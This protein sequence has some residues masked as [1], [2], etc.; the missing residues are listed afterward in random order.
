MRSVWSG[1][2]PLAG[3]LVILNLLDGT[4]GVDLA[5]NMVGVGSA[6]RRYLAYEPEEVP[7]IFRMLDLIAHGGEGHDLA[8]LLLISDCD[9]GFL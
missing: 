4:V 8:H 1:K 3:T 7:R 6:L 9:L 2:M 5:V